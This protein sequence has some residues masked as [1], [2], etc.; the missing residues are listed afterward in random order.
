M[1]TNYGKVGRPGSPAAL[2]GAAH[3]FL[4]AFDAYRAERGIVGWEES[5]AA[6]HLTQLR[7]Q[8]TLYPFAANMPG[9][10]R[11]RDRWRAAWRGFRGVPTP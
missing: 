8:L 2:A 3:L 1:E 7:E 9:V 6:I 5:P 10:L 11:W 4:I